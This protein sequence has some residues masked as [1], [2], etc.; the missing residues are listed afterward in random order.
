MISSDEEGA[1][2]SDESK[3]KTTKQQG[4]DKR[5]V[6]LKERGGDREESSSVDGAGRSRGY[7]YAPSSHI[8]PAALLYD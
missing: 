5:G 4:A 1:I 7:G 3:S 2:D 8:S 6:L